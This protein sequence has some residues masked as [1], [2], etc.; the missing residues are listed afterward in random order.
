[1]N[2][3]DVAQ[4]IGLTPNIVKSLPYGVEIEEGVHPCHA[5]RFTIAVGAW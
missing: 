5:H 2:D 4:R 1:M 3:T